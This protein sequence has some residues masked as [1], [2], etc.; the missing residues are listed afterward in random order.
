MDVDLQCDRGLFYTLSK[1][2]DI[3]WTTAGKWTKGAGP[4]REAKLKG[5]C[6]FRTSHRR[7]STAVSE[8]LYE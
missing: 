6:G 7:D 4:S 8:P 3:V 1:E 5:R 2:L